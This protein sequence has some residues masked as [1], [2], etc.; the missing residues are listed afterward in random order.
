[1]AMIKRQPAGRGSIPDAPSRA[2]HLAEVLKAVA[3]PL[4]L[5]V[6]A[7]LCEGD[8]T[9]GELAARLEVSQPILS[10]QL[11]IL[12]LRGLVEVTRGGGFG[13]YRIGEPR[14]HDLVRC[15]ERCSVS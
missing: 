6:V 14:L 7:L 12:R 10:Q 9:V 13:R 4:R 5:R 2:E 8:S 3:H 1:M 11:R 15:M